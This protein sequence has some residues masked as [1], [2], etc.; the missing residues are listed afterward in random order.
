MGERHAGAVLLVARLHA[1]GGGAVDRRQH[2]GLGL[3][4]VAFHGQAETL[5]LA[6]RVAQLGQAAAAIAVLRVGRGTGV[7]EAAHVTLVVGSLARAMVD[8]DHA[9]PPNFRPT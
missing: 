9:A 4:F 3:V 1:G 2:V 7:V 8:V 6:R 5:V